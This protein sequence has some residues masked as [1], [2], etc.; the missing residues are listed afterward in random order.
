M[1][2]PREHYRICFKPV[3]ERAHLSNLLLTMAQKMGVER[4]QFADSNGVVSEVLA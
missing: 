3:N 2:H 1:S 4:E